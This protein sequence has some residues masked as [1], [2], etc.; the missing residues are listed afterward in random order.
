MNTKWINN[1][2]WIM[3]TIYSSSDKIVSFLACT[4]ISYL[5]QASVT[6]CQ[7]LFWHTTAIYC[8]QVQWQPFLKTWTPTLYLLF[9]ITTQILVCQTHTCF[10]SLWLFKGKLLFFFQLLFYKELGTAPGPKS[11]TACFITQQNL[12][13]GYNLIL[14]TKPFFILKNN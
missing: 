9:L 8:R 1:D 3:N 11:L 6:T 7:T 4:C 14:N 5:L 13:T 2:M 12:N 10:K